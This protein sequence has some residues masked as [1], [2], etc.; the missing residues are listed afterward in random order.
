MVS[1]F[2]FLRFVRKLPARIRIVVCG[3]PLLGCAPLLLAVLASALVVLLHPLL[4]APLGL[5]MQREQRLDDVV[6]LGVPVQRF[7]PPT[8]V[9]TPAEVCNL[10]DQSAS[11]QHAVTRRLRVQEPAEDVAC[12]GEDRAPLIVVGRVARV[13]LPLGEHGL[14]RVD[15]ALDQRPWHGHTPYVW[16]KVVKIVSVRDPHAHA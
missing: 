2:A 3:R 6:G 4:V 8:L 16:V 14:K 11:P 12:R 13:V 15:V 9:P 10:L 5:L 7:N 1:P